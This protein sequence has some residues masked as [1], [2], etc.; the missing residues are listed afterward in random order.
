MT[1]YQNGAITKHKFSK[2][3]DTIMEVLCNVHAYDTSNWLYAF[4]IGVFL[5]ELLKKREC[6]DE[7]DDWDPLRKVRSQYQK[8][9]LSETGYRELRDKASYKTKSNSWVAPLVLM[10]VNFVSSQV[11]VFVFVFGFCFW[12]LFLVRLILRL[13]LGCRHCGSEAID[14][15][16][17]YGSARV[18]RIEEMEPR[19][20]LATVASNFD[21]ERTPCH[22]I[23]QILPN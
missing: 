18:L 19:R 4:S 21:P 15:R 23:K 2:I 11:F 6:Q 8:G 14:A 20:D 7:N 16:R 9:R 10:K 5:L 13:E 12:I 1:K 3:F 22:C 17:R